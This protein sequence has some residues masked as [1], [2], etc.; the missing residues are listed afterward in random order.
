MARACYSAPPPPPFCPQC[1]TSTTAVYEDE[2]G[3]TTY[4]CR[5]CGQT[6]GRA[7]STIEESDMPPCTGRFPRLPT[8]AAPGSSE[9]KRVMLLRAEA[10]L[11]I[12]H[13]DDNRLHA[14][15]AEQEQKLRERQLQID[16]LPG[17]KLPRGVTWE[18]ATATHPR[19]HWRVR[20][21]DGSGLWIGS[22]Q[23][24]AIDVGRFDDL[25]D[26]IAALEAARRANG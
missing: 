12:L 17:G 4:A 19:G 24:K 18:N 7:L 9:K 22:K 11:Q 10:G 15:R 25:D 26:A 20:L 13:P 21:V 16:A 23:D 2:D 14:D 5:D 6:F 8:S 1:H 3:I